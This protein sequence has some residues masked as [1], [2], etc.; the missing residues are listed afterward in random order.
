MKKGSL[1][2]MRGWFL[3]APPDESYIALRGDEE[4]GRSTELPLHEIG[5]TPSPSRAQSYGTGWRPKDAARRMFW[6]L[7]PSFL[8]RA[9]GHVDEDGAIPMASATSYLNGL[10]GLASFIVTIGHNTDDYLWIYRGWG[11]TAEDRY[12]VQLPFIRLAFCGI[13]M[14]T[15]FFVISGFVLTYSPLKKS[16]AGQG[17]DAIGSLPS[18]IFRRP[19][20]LFMPVVPILIITCILI[21]YQA[22][23][24]APGRQPHGPV[25]NGVWSQITFIWRT[26]ITIITQSTTATIMPQG[27]TLSVEYQGSLLKLPPLLAGAAHKA[28]NVASWL[29]LVFALFLG[30][31]PTHGNGYAAAGYSWFTW[32]PTAGID[33]TRLFPSIAAVAL[34]AAL[35]N[36][37]VLQRCLNS[38][39]VLYLGEISY[40]LYLVHWVVGRSFATWGLKYQMLD[41]GYS[42]ATAW[43]VTFVI[44][45]VLSIWLGD[46]YWRLVDR[47]SVQLAQWLS[48]KLGI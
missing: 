1:K 11:E 28:A 37:P 30:G 24:V 26:L 48:R 25:A 7:L 13:Y 15:I 44:M 21:H 16:H 27:W 3:G 23:Y 10:R 22:F 12:L 42:M 18:S 6:L 36:L 33:P 29:L 2:S 45:L 9:L 39:W 34:V 19:F 14:V 8:S 31:W 47:K 46:V 4:R 32:V 41:A 5:A 20:R 43:S 35:E 40:G 38:R 17:V